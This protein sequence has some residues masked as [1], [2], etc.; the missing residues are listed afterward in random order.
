MKVNDVVFTPQDVAEIMAQEGL[1]LWQDVNGK[2]MI[3]ARILDPA[4]GTGNL[5]EACRNYVYSLYLEYPDIT[6]IDIRSELLE[7]AKKRIPEGKFYCFDALAEASKIGKFDFIIAN[8]PYVSINC[9]GKEKR[10]IYK[11]LYS[12]CYGRVDLYILFL[13]LGWRLLKENGVMAFII[14]NNWL[15]SQNGTGIRRLFQEEQADLYIIEE[16][17]KIFKEQVFTHFL[18]AVKRKSRSIKYFFRR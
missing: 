8:P 4:C 10:E 17:K 2:Q 12:S 1:E 14:P 16:G 18:F 11:K 15:K 9:I 3:K 6:G 13:E 5:L 7:V